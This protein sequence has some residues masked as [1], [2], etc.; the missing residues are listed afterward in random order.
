[1]STITE[2]SSNAVATSANAS[3]TAS[4]KALLIHVPFGQTSMATLVRPLGAIERM[5]HRQSEVYP[6]HFSVAAELTG[7]FTPTQLQA[8]LAAVQKRHPLLRVHIEDQPGTRLGFYQPAIVPAIPLTVFEASDGYTWQQL[9]ATEVSMRLD[10][11][12]APLVRA[13][14]LRQGPTAATLILSFDHTVADG[15]SA[16]FVLEDI[17]A[18][19]NGYELAILPTTRSQEEWLAALPSSL[20]AG[21]APAPAPP[22]DERLSALVSLAPFAGA[23][24]DLSTLT[25]NEAFTSQLVQRCRAEQTTVHAALVAATTQVMLRVGHREVVRVFSPFNFR[26]LL[27]E[28]M[29]DCGVYFN[30]AR[31]GFLPEQTQDFWEL[32]RLTSAELAKARSEAGTRGVSAA[33][34]QFIPAEVT[35][36]GAAGFVQQA[37][38]CET[39]MSNLGV[40]DVPVSGAVQVAAVWGPIMLGRFQDES[41]LG[42]ATLHGQLRLVYVSPAPIPDFL[43]LVQ[44]QLTAHLGAPVT[45]TQGTLDT[46][47]LRGLMAQETDY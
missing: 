28:G 47:Y 33:I 41:M 25:L 29:R 30:A 38:S 18:V 37:L 12:V 35:A 46:G 16:V 2:N 22:I 32:A 10:P 23:V 42:I 39:L 40:L 7:A 31:T 24:P 34:E 14:L 13:V 3:L 43:P 1:M 5:L 9:A 44:A 19:L 11:R 8:A 27:G 4:T 36:A 17:L 21:D 15:L 45:S 20:P 6:I 26:K